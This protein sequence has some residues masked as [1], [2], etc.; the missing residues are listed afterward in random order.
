M[1]SAINYIAYY[2]VST[3]QQGVSGLGLEAQQ[4][5]VQDFAGR[6]GAAIVASYTEVESGKKTNRVQLLEAIA[7][8]KKTGSTLLIAKL[9]RLAR[10]AAFIFHLRDTGVKFVAADMP[11]ANTLTVGIIAVMA[12]HEAELIS[13]R[14]KAALAAKRQRGEKLGNAGNFSAAGRAKGRAANTAN[15]ANNQN[16]KTARGYAVLLSKSGAS[17]RKI[18]KTLNDEGFKTARGGQYSAMQVSNLFA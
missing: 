3:Q 9:D 6:T 5:Q 7:E 4:K 2:R 17:L 13:A 14:T 1:S 15:A 8:A 12:Q 11:E 10:N 18:A 16:T